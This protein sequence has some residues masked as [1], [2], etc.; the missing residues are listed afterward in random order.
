M[1]KFFGKKPVLITFIALAVIFAVVY[2]GMLVRPVA[3]G[4]TY[5]GTITNPENITETV[6]VSVKFKSGKKAEM[7][8]EGEK[9]TNTIYY[10]EKDGYVVF[11]PTVEKDEDYKDAKEAALENWETTKTYVK[12][13]MGGEDCTAFSAKVNGAELKCTGSVVFAI[14]GGV[15]ELVLLAG[16]GLS[17][18]YA[19][20]K[21]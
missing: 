10:F 4:M 13:G 8:I 12:L 21:K 3:I 6:N 14:I 9:E 5:K 11:L 2:I 1:K 17:V 20:K 18:F 16:A 15:L 19:V 7:K